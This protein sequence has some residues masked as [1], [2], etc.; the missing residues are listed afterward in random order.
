[1]NFAGIRWLGQFIFWK[2]P[3]LSGNPENHSRNCLK[4]LHPIFVTIL[5]LSIISIRCENL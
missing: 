3:K 5:W 1:M 2:I 4:S